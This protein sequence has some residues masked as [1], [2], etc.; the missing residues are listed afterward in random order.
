MPRPPD[1]PARRDHAAVIRQA[2]ELARKDDTVEASLG[3]NV[4]PIRLHPVALGERH[5]LVPRPVSVLNLAPVMIPNPPLLDPADI[6]GR[7]A[8][9]LQRW[10]EGAVEARTK[11]R[12][13]S[14]RS[15]RA[16]HITQSKHFGL[17]VKA[18]EV[19]IAHDIAPAAWCAFSMDVWLE[20]ENKG[21][22]PI[23][24]AFSPKRIEERRGWFRSV[25]SD[26]SGGRVLHSDAGRELMQRQAR[27]DRALRTLPGDATDEQI[28]ACVSGVLTIEHQARLIA[29]VQEAAKLMNDDLANKV[30]AGEWVW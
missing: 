26:Y 25:S 16:G 9:L 6:P 30:Y 19:F 14:F 18:A 10:F 21:A 3:G 23:P 22:M 27:L 29:S 1:R 13:W 24:W 28:S 5:P 17:L 4:A 15:E 20:H 8:Y 11:K 12:C 2:T 7:K